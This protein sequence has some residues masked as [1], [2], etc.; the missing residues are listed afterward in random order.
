MMFSGVLQGAGDTVII[1]LAT[2]TSLSV[3]VVTGYLTAH[4]G[5]LDYSAAW[6]P[7]PIGWTFWSIIIYSRYFSGKWK[8]KAVVGRLSRAA[9]SAE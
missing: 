3:R 7:I 2:L 8:S 4:F 9:E 6:I 5:I 1:T